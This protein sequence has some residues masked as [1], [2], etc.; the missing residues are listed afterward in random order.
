MIAVF[1]VVIF[2]TVIILNSSHKPTL[3]S[4]KESRAS[5]VEV[6]LSPT[7]NSPTFRI[8]G[9]KAGDDALFNTGKALGQAKRLLAAG[10]DTEAEKILKTI[11][12]FRPN[13][14]QAL[15][16]LAG[17]Y[18]YSGR[19]REAEAIFRKQIKFNKTDALAY[20][21]LGSVLAKQDKFEEAATFVSTAVGLN[22]DAG[23]YHINLAGI[24]SMLNKKK[25]AIKHFRKAYELISAGILPLSYDSAFDN[26]R[27]MPEFREILTKAEKKS[28]IPEKR[29][30]STNSSAG[31]KKK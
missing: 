21:R 4:Y 25:L 11:L 2:L 15:S 24:F 20:N 17:I 1:A 18:F 14:H 27:S 10:K 23:L 22:P 31:F 26:I 5:N 6:S 12:V 19:Y 29:E 7:K 30:K 13:N 3:S 28:T 9:K 8:N 16:L